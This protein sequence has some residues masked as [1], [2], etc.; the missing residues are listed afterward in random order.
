VFTHKISNTLLRVINA[1]G[2]RKH[3]K[4]PLTCTNIYRLFKYYAIIIKGSKLDAITHVKIFVLG[5]K[6]ANKLLTVLSP[7]PQ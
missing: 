1:T 4:I 7:P 6:D 3:Y 2:D 5:K